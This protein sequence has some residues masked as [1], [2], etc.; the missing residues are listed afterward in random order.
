[1]DA[2]KI[3]SGKTK[4]TIRGETYNKNLKTTSSSRSLPASSEI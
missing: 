3:V 1:M 4:T 2:S